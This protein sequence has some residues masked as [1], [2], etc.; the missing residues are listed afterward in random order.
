MPNFGQSFGLTR[1]AKLRIFRALHEEDSL[2]L[3]N[4]ASP[5]LNL[6]KAM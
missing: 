4:A 2:W 5:A 6:Q 1:V 3:E